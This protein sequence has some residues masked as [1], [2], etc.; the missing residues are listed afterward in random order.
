MENTVIIDY[1]T[2]NLKSVC[3]ALDRIGAGWTLSSDPQ[4]ISKARR[5]LLPGVGDA[6]CAM[7]ELRTRGLDEVVRGLS[8]PV[9]GICVGMQLMCLSSEEGNVG[10]LGIFNT[11]VRRLNADPAAAVKVPHVGWNVLS[12]LK[13]PLFEGIECGTFAYFVHSYAASLCEDTIAV[14]QHG[15]S[16]SA[17]L[18]KEN[19]F[20]VQFHPE[21]SGEAGERILRNFLNL[22]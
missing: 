19:F 1:A 3:N 10:C 4:V 16:F 2:G 11:R 8:V 6:S 22:G 7:K 21:K 14:S 13:S 12:S 18:A 9:L 15:I 5:V 20:G 17:A